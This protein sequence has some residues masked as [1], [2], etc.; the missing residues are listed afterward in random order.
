VV[1]EVSGLTYHEYMRRNIFAPLG[2][3]SARIM[4]R[5][6][7]E[8][9]LAAGYEVSGGSVRRVP[10]EW[11]HSTPSSSFAATAADMAKFVVS[12]LE[13]GSYNGARILSERA[14]G[15]MQ[16]QHVT[17]HPLIPG[18]AYGWQIRDANGQRILEHGGDIGGFSSVVTLLPDAR[19]GF[20]V[21]GHREGANL[22]FAVRDAVLDRY[23]P[24]RAPIVPPKIDSTGAERVSRFA[25]TYRANIYCHTCPE[26]LRFTQDFRITA[27]RDGTLSGFD[28]RWVE[29]SPLFFRDMTGTRRFGLAADSSGRITALTIGSWQVL[30]KI[31]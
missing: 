18:W 6:G 21:V 10:Y 1:E 19:T 4:A 20:V 26:S 8:T 22:R 29:V 5:P 9:G 11:Y 27:N 2:M 7:D 13:G 15:D 28:G 24:R 3:R 17:M 16:T 30:E 31:K 23:F 14:T 25:G 12:Q